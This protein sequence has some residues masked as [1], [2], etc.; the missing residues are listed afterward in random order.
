MFSF[1]VL[2]G[3]LA[4]FVL[5]LWL[6]AFFN[7]CEIGFYRVSFLRL[8]IDSQ[9]G[10]RQA[11]RILWFAQNPAYFVATALVGNNFSNYITTVA[12]GLATVYGL[13]AE[14]G[15]VEIVGTLAIAPVAFICGELIPKSLY[16][17]S[18]L[19]LLRRGVGLFRFFYRLLLPLS[20]PLI[21]LTKLFERFESGEGKP[22]GFVLGRSQLV[23]VLS[24][25]HR[26]G[27]ITDLQSRLIDSLMHTASQPVTDSLIPLHRV[28]GLADDVG[29]P[30]VLAF[31]RHYGLSSIS[32]KRAG[33]DDEWY[34]YVRVV[35]AAVD[36]RP[37]SECLRK[38]SRI[39]STASKLEALV[40]LRI[41]GAAY[42][43]VFKEGRVVGIVSERGMVEQMFRPKHAAAVRLPSP[44]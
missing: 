30:Q 13:G 14:S 26:E 20:F 9:A 32:I 22:L 43:A 18:P 39:P 40:A 15:W 5:G 34:A 33:T 7:G 10:D 2:T 35:D 31:A 23:Q 16:Y 36:H 11:G 1:L 3:A 12:V 25:G 4:L 19:H 21:W 44:T 37:L 27:L 8:N 6:S 29:T 17:W 28:L 24:Q 38:M 41:A 42:G